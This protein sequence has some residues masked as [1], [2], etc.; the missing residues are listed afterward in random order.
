VQV[1]SH[2]VFLARA[3]PDTSVSLTSISLAPP[4]GPSVGPAG[5]PHEGGKQTGWGREGC[6]LGL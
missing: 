5:A 4:S 1:Q 3:E 6:D 2:S